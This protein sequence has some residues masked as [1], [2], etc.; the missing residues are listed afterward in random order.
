MM[1]HSAHT[2]AE[3]REVNGCWQG[4]SDLRWGVRHWSTRIGVDPAEVHIRP[5]R[6]KWGSMSTRGR[7][8]LDVQLLEL[9]RSLGEYVIVHELLHL[10]VPSHSRVFKAFLHAYMPDWQARDRELQALGSH[11]S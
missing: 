7:L 4:E 9:P 10:R 8:T 5:M 2:D 3:R 6:T 1:K 11:S